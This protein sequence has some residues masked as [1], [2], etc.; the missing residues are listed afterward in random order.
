MGKDFPA[1][2]IAM[3]DLL[4]INSHHN[5]LR[6]KTLGRLANKVGVINCRRVNSHFIGTGIQ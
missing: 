4:G 5:T 6:T 3:F 2:A 1:R